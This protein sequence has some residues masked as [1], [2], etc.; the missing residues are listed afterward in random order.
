MSVSDEIAAAGR[1]LRRLIGAEDLQDEAVVNVFANQELARNVGSTPRSANEL[2]A[3]FAAAPRQGPLTA[4][5]ICGAVAAFWKWAGAGFRTVDATMR[6]R[7]L[8]ACIQCDDYVDAPPGS[9]Y[10]AAAAMARETKICRQCG[11]FIGKKLR[12]ASE[13]CPRNAWPSQ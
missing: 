2:Y 12:L 8:E 5:T 9:L 1:E 4:E 13:T 6:A 11:C 7:R 3:I 10:S